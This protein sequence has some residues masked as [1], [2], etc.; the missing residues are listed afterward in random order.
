MTLHVAASTVG[1]LGSLIPLMHR[2]IRAGAGMIGHAAMAVAMTLML[3]A[4]LAPSAAVWCIV[5][6]V[7]VCTAAAWHLTA[8]HTTSTQSARCIVDLVAMSAAML[9]SPFAP[10][11][12]HPSTTVPQLPHVSM[13]STT[14][15]HLGLAVLILWAAA[16]AALVVSDRVLVDGGVKRVETAGSF[17]MMTAMGAM[18]IER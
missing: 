3:A 14:P 5:I 9:A 7:S 18:M 2:A 15:T 12:V 1:V 10:H 16:S 17:L 4:S 8:T 13:H 11:T 6:Q